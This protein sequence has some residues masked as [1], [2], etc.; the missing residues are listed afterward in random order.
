MLML[1]AID[2]F[3][4][5]SRIWMIRGEV[6]RRLNFIL[7]CTDAILPFN[8]PKGEVR[9]KHHSLLPRKPRLLRGPFRL[10]HTNYHKLMTANESQ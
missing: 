2:I 9:E 10:L 5:D 6:H 3:G 1:A 7:G 8:I 4:C